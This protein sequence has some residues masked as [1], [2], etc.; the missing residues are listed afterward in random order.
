MIITRLRVLSVALLI[1][2]LGAAS[3]QALDAQM[4]HQ[5]LFTEDDHD[6]RLRDVAID[7]EGRAWL[8]VT[9]RDKG[10][11]IT[12]GRLALWRLTR[13]GR[14]DLAHPVV[15]PPAHGARHPAG[16]RAFVRLG[17]GGHP[18]VA[19]LTDAGIGIVELDAADGALRD[20][21][22]VEGTTAPVALE[23]REGGGWT[24][25]T[26]ERVFELQAAHTVRDMLPAA[27]PA[28]L[29]AAQPVRGRVALVALDVGAAH[30]ARAHLGWLPAQTEGGA[31][32]S[33]AP[34]EVQV[35]LRHNVSV[36]HGDGLLLLSPVRGDPSRWQTLA[37][38]AGG[39]L[40]ASVAFDLPRRGKQPLTLDAQP[41]AGGRTLLAGARG[42]ALWLG[43]LGADGALADVPIDAA[44]GNGRPPAMFALDVRLRQSAASGDYLLLGTQAVANAATDKVDYGIFVGRVRLSAPE[45]P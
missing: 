19:A 17:D 36:S 12:A 10:A 4:T 21:W 18:V 5:I 15:S 23:R 35:N 13:D 2:A 16:A 8:L 25:I 34:L 38:D 7:G 29:V 33:A 27:P 14:R 20:H 11:P 45:S 6:L 9:L 31:A 30:A 43:V 40:T 3:A 44:Q 28:P 41:L 42:A 22:L 24:L 39:N 37:F 26:A 32:F 1:A